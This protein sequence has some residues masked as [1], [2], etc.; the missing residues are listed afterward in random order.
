MALDASG[1]RDLRE[2]LLALIKALRER[3]SRSPPARL[4]PTSPTIH[5]LFPELPSLQELSFM[6]SSFP[7]DI[8]DVSH[9]EVEDSIG[10][11]PPEDTS[12]HLQPESDGAPASSPQGASQQ[13]LT[14]PVSETEHVQ[15]SGTHR[16]STIELDADPNVPIVSGSL[17]RYAIYIVHASFLIDQHDT[18][19]VDVSSTG[20]TVLGLVDVDV[21]VALQEI[22]DELV[23]HDL[24]SNDVHVAQD[25]MD[26]FVDYETSVDENEVDEDEDGSG[27]SEMS[28]DDVSLSD[29]L[30]IEQEGS[31]IGPSGESTTAS[32]LD[33][34]D[35][36]HYYDAKSLSDVPSIPRAVELDQHEQNSPPSGSQQ[37]GDGSD[38]GPALDPISPE[39]NTGDVVSNADSQRPLKLDTSNG[40]TGN[41]KPTS[42]EVT[43]TT[44][45]EDPSGDE[46]S[47]SSKGR[48]EQ[49]EELR[50]YKGK[51]R[52][53]R[54]SLS[55]SVTDTAEQTAPSPVSQTDPCPPVKLRSLSEGQMSPLWYLFKSAQTN[56]WR[57]VRPGA[58]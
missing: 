25:T 55:L 2:D 49:T 16:D 56:I 35:E 40:M 27:L 52:S 47:W 36:A 28:D 45:C 38:K 9:N 23:A 53:R 21:A 50:S 34:E 24:L 46:R 54:T 26:G 39:E 19:E 44:L 14:D 33:H 15:D 5:G 58:A 11:T 18:S 41:L 32:D 12:S 8:E 31:T 1:I 4:T 6:T 20:A 51:R 57:Q 43:S 13:E 3:A 37:E 22:N 7:S 29:S 42:A 30:D 10:E 17:S 48:K